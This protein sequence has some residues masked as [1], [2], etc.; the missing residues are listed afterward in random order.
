MSSGIYLV[1]DDG[2]LVE[3][4]EQSYGSEALLEELLELY[5]NLL[6]G[7]RVDREAL[8]EWLVIIRQD[9]GGFEDSRTD[10]W[11]SNRIFLDRDAV[12]TLVEIDFSVAPQL[13]QG[14]VGQL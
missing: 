3:M 7:E 13:R 14:T 11:A 12:P 8:D 9:G 10:L 2:R 1:R 4:V 5:P 6:N